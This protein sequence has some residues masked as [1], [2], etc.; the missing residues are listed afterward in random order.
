MA[1]TIGEDYTSLE[2]I[3][4]TGGIVPDANW[5]ANWVHFQKIVEVAKEFNIKL[6]T[7]HAGFVPHEPEDPSYN[8]LRDRMLQLSE[9]FR[10]NGMNLGLE[11]GQETAPH[12][13]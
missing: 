8:K 1:E 4:R 5:E 2:S 11:T 13:K 10:D 6:V 12:R 7:F 3:R 9:L